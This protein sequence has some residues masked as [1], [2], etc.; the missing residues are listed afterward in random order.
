VPFREH[1]RA[2]QDV[3]VE[4]LDRRAHPRERV[5]PARRVAIDARD[6][7]RRE[8]AAQRLLEALR[9]V[10]LR[11]QVD[12]AAFGARARDRPSMAAVVAAQPLGRAVHDEPRRAPCALRFPAARRA[13][14]RR[15]VAAPVDEDQ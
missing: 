4:R 15:R 2:D 5:A 1:L 3:D 14:E 12:V 6:A 7:R 9:A 10:A 11:Q 8:R 13:L